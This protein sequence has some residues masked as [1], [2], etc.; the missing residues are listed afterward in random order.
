MKGAATWGM[1]T[2]CDCQRRP[3]GKEPNMNIYESLQ[4]WL[5]LLWWIFPVVLF[6][7]G[8]LVPS[9]RLPV[10]ASEIPDAT[11]SDLY[12]WLLVSLVLCGIW[13]LAAF[14]QASNHTTS[15]TALKAHIFVSI[16]L[17]IVLAATSGFLIGHNN[18]V[19]ALVLPTGASIIEALVTAD[20]AINNAAQRP[21]VHHKKLAA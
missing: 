21:I 19:W 6:A 5:G 4:R 12:F 15:I 11:R 20:R 9:L 1:P 13:V 16:L 14:F 8:L 7:G 3:T 18:L 10:A 17:S 2:G